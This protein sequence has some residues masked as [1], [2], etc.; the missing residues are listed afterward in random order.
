MVHTHHTTTCSLLPYTHFT[1]YPKT[2]RKINF[3]IHKTSTSSAGAG[4]S[5]YY[6]ILMFFKCCW[7]IHIVSVSCWWWSW[8]ASLFVRSEKRSDG[9]QRNVP[10]MERWISHLGGGGDSKEK[11]RNSGHGERE[12][13]CWWKAAAAGGEKEKE[14]ERDCVW[15]IT[16]VM[17]GFECFQFECQF[18]PGIELLKYPCDAQQHIPV[19]VYGK[20]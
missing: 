2:Q 17:V 5:L 16:S 14:R 18:L 19:K 1:C 6:I 9:E 10:D 13:S 11:R 3:K 20:F 15:E 12:E 4:C 8:S 7:I